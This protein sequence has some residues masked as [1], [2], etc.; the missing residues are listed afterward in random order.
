M[1]TA[2]LFFVS[3][4]YKV[5]KTLD[6][7]LFAIT[8]EGDYFYMGNGYEEDFEKGKSTYIPPEQHS[9]LFAQIKFED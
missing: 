1:K 6:G 9:E 5:Y 7:Y 8:P 3:E 4:E 2:T